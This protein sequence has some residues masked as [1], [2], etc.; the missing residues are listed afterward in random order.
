[1]RQ[2]V[3]VASLAFFLG[4]A[5]GC[6]SADAPLTP[7]APAPAASSATGDVALKASAP[8][9]TSP[10]GDKKLAVGENDLVLAASPATA[11]F[12]TGVPLRYQFQVLDNKGATMIDSGIVPGPSTTVDVSGLAIS[13]RHTWRTRAEF[14]GN[15]GPWS[16]AASFVT[17]DTPPDPYGNYQKIC[18]GLDDQDLVSCLWQL[19]KPGDE[20]EAFEVTKRYAW[21]MRGDG[22]GLLIKNGGENVVPWQG[23]NFAA[24]RICY[25]D[26][27]IFKLMSDVGPG[28]ANSPAF[29]DNDFVDK[30]LFFPAIDPSKK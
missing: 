16:T 20:F 21:M 1:M 9:P 24:A 27:H 25:P 2:I 12:Q 8:T 4:G 26:G 23:H 30:S 5:I 22:A 6:S 7:A 19:V 11:L 14:Q 15:F 28:G 17:A 3:T 13:T 10:Q 18:A 29:Q